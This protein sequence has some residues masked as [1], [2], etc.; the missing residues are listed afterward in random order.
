M[1][2]DCDYHY[3]PL[4]PHYTFHYPLLLQALVQPCPTPEHPF[5]PYLLRFPE[6]IFPGIKP[7]NPSFISLYPKSFPLCP[8]SLIRRPAVSAPIPARLNLINTNPNY[9][10]EQVICLAL[11]TN[12]PLFERR[13][14]LS[15]TL[16]CT[17][18]GDCKEAAF[19]LIGYCKLDSQINAQY[20]P[21]PEPPEPKYSHCC[22]GC[23]LPYKECKEGCN[24]FVETL[25]GYWVHIWDLSRRAFT[26]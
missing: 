17:H 23:D 7:I 14:E 19:A 21:I 9:M 12:F 3:T 15:P 24:T 8:L 1:K 13:C 11:C 18:P 20:I 5:Y 4:C 16:L 6:S 26:T 2:S 22:L 10:P 25:V